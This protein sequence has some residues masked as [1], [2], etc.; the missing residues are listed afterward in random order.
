MTRSEDHYVYPALYFRSNLRVAEAKRSQRCALCWATNGA[1][2]ASGSSCH[3][4]R[5]KQA[6]LARNW[7]FF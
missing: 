6:L 2:E 1:E 7:I 3:I 4:L 5:I